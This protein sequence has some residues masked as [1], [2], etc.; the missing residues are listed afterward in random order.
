MLAHLETVIAWNPRT[1][2]RHPVLMMFKMTA[3]RDVATA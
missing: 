2:S 3:S 1:P